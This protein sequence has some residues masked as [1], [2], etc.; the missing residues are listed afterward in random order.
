M[1]SWFQWPPIPDNFESTLIEEPCNGIYISHLHPDH[2]DPKFLAKFTKRNPNVP[3]FIAEFAHSWL[4]RSIAA[5]VDSNT[6][7]IEVPSLKEFEIAKNF[8]LKIFAAD[9]CNPQI[10]GTNIPCQINPKIRGI[11]S[12]AVFNAD[13]ISVVNAN[14]AMGVKLIPRIAANIGKAD[15]IMGH[16]GGAS[17]YPQCF[18]EVENKKEAAFKVVESTCKMLLSAADALNVKWIMPFAGQYVLGGRLTNLNDD[19]ATLALDQTVDYLRKLTER[20]IVS[21]KPMGSIDLTEG[22]QDEKYVEPDDNAKR[23]YF[24]IIS[25]KIFPYEKKNLK[26]WEN[27]H[28]DLLA[29]ASPVIERSA[30][31]SIEKPISFVIGDG[32]NFVTINLNPEFSKSHAILGIHS[33]SEDTTT[34]TMPQELLKRLSTRSKEYSGFTTMHWNQADVGSHFTWRRNGE[35]NLT[36][37]M[38]LNFFGI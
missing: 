31:A 37:H 2:Y 35:F 4:K 20:E 33:E 34:I 6:Q 7:V 30:N 28:E 38:L 27:I 23:L 24:E 9:S 14:D 13:N 36:G 3:V 19:R 15:L 26:N 12:I 1:G 11:D 32:Q 21:V 18:P 5:V 25:K 16:Y 8:S 29:A 10:C 17:P 22:W